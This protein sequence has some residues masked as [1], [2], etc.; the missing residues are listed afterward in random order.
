M[1]AKHSKGDLW[2]Q[3]PREVQ[4]QSQRSCRSLAECKFREK[5]QRMK[6]L[7]FVYRGG[8]RISQEQ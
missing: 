6:I 5:E 2:N 4:S 7:K 1:K 3:G 8:T